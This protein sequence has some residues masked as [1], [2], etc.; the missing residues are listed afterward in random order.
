MNQIIGSQFHNKSQESVPPTPTL[1]MI[2][3]MTS[4]NLIPSNLPGGPQQVNQDP[5]AVVLNTSCPS[6]PVNAQIQVQGQMNHMTPTYP[7][8]TLVRDNVPP[9]PPPVPG[10]PSLGGE[11]GN[12]ILDRPPTPPPAVSLNLMSHVGPVTSDSVLTRQIIATRPA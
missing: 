3:Y 1:I 6:T 2:P 11:P 8:G 9:P 10:F 4:P 12:L 5:T 7:P